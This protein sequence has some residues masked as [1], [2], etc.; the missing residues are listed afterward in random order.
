MSWDPQHNKKTLLIENQGTAKR[1][2]YKLTGFVRHTTPAGQTYLE[3]ISDGWYWQ[4]IEFQAVE[5]VA[6]YTVRRDAQAGELNLTGG[7]RPPGFGG[8]NV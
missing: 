7:N 4:G 6:P 8:R 3:P 5:F 2:L 1:P